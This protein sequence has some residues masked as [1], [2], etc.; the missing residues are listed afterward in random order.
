MGR[1]QSRMD[2]NSK[3]GQMQVVVSDRD[4][5]SFLIS[6]K[7]AIEAG[8]KKL[9]AELLNDRA[10]EQVDLLLK[11]DPSRTDVMF[12]LALMFDRIEQLDKA[13]LWYRKII[14]QNPNALAFHRLASIFK[15]SQRL[16]DAIE[17][18]RQSVRIE[19]DNVRF[20]SCLGVD[21]VEAGRTLEGLEVL[22]LATQKE[23]Q[24]P[25]VHSRYLF[26]MHYLPDLDPDM[27]LNEHMQWGLL[28][29]PVSRAKKFHDN[30]P[31]PDRRLRIGYIS[32]DFRRHSA[33]YNFEAFLNRRDSAKFEVYGYGNVCRP[34]DMTERLK[35]QFDH[36][37]DIHGLQD[38]HIADLVEQ[39]SIDILVEIGGHTLDNRLAV[40]AYKPAPIQVSYGGLST[41]G[42]QQ[43]DY[44]L[45]DDVLDPPEYHRFYAEES[46]CL[47]GGLFCYSPPDFAPPVAP[48]PAHRNGF[49]TFGSFNNS[50]KINPYVVS[51]W[52]QTLKASGNSRLVLKYPGGND[53]GVRDYFLSEFEKSGITRDRIDIYGWKSP[54]E[55]MGLYNRVDIA[56]DTYPFNGCITTLEALW[57]GVPVISLAGNNSLLSRTGLSILS[58]VGLESFVAHSPAAFVAKAS[59]FAAG[60][61]D[62]LARIRATMRTRMSASTLCDAGRFARELEDAY[63]NIWR[64]WCRSR[65]KGISSPGLPAPIM[66]QPRGD[67]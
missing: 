58:R 25:D 1:S 52:A 18:Q 3:T 11:Q 14:E 64:R 51:L 31:D 16:L 66:V 39:D 13:E 50:M 32:A 62:A 60:N 9:A 2:D 61:L 19:P 21:L 63:R 30:V 8:N 38:R 43:I 37:R 54:V 33:A 28:H 6:A 17:Y 12:M 49:L 41:S 23:P 56:L 53:M 35:P 24:S 46:I 15:R 40:L 55:H 59:A 36:Y 20:L 47:P 42:M 5:P 7:N 48:T 34:D 29:T 27:L 65:D 45:T 10:I 57:M 67:L 22:R 26:H 4:L 44:R